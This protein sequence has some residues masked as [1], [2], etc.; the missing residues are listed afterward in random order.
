MQIN[1]PGDGP[2]VP[3]FTIIVAPLG[4]PSPDYNAFSDGVTGS[5]REKV[6]RFRRA[7]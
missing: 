1:M 3:T 6:G 5:Y 4:H 2:R 7:P